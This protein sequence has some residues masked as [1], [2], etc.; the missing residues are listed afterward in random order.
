MRNIAI[1]F[2][3]SICILTLPLVGLA[4]QPV[5][6]EV[7]LENAQKMAA[8]S[9][10][11]VLIYFWAPWCGACKAMEADILSQ[12]SVNGA[13]AANYVPVKIN[14][15][16]FRSTAM[17]YGV[18]ALPTTVITTPQGQVLDTMQGRVEAAPLVARM[19][20]VVA[21]A[22]QRAGS[23]YAQ[24]PTGTNPTA[25][26]ARPA[27]QTPPAASQPPAADTQ[28]PNLNGP[29]LVANRQ[30][31]PAGNPAPSI[32]RK[33]NMTDDRYA[34]FYRRNQS[35]PAMPI[36]QPASPPMDAAMQ[37]NQPSQPIATAALPIGQ[38]PAPAATAPAY[39]S[40]TPSMPIQQAANP[41]ISPPQYNQS[42]ASA[43][44]S[45]V[46]QAPAMRLPLGLDGYCP[47]SL[48]EKGQWI[49]G[50]RRWGAEHRGRT[51]LFSG[52]NEQQRFFSDPDRYAPVISGHDIVLATEQNK[53][54]PGKR[55]Y[56]DFCG[57][58]IY[59]FSSQAS[60]EKF[61]KNPGFYANQAMGAMRT[62]A[63][64]GQPLQ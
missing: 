56:G 25:S 47:M 45:P 53:L 35:S 3:L 46:P 43:Q 14:A 8:Q 1:F 19:G 12:P 7:S 52:P 29:A 39:G 36:A 32:E 48:T 58:R 59:L 18:T 63:N 4:Q 62:G 40:Q 34:D 28:S 57:N 6:W 41:A 49:P 21:S 11:L 61:E 5:R 23:V 13:L 10:R 22:K 30:V 55:E 27:A 16:N 51:Y 50:D 42:L 44:A 54:V 37:T 33:S 64:A 24:S 60:M 17:K 31:P 9:N 26:I 38:L 20:Q 15:D 2:C